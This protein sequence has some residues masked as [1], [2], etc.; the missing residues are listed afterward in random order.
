MTHF[1]WTTII[2]AV[3][4][5]AAVIFGHGETRT[6]QI[7]AIVILYIVAFG[8]GM[9]FISLQ[10]FVP[11]IYRGGTGRKQIALTFDDGPDPFSTP[12]LLDLLKRENVTATFFCIGRNVVAYPEIAKRI[13]DEGHLIGNHSHRHAWTLM[14][15]RNRGLLREFGRA[16]DAITRI[17]G[18][19]P[20]LL[21]PPVGM[22]NPHFPW[23]IKQLGVTVLAW[24]VRPLDTARPAKKVIRHV[25][26][27]A[28]DGSIVVL[29]DGGAPA[30]KITEIVGT[31]VKELRAKGYAFERVDRMI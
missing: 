5:L 8:L 12:A 13:V 23:L 31:L 11:A 20:T 30:E 26:K 9:T 25:L 14:F 29:H 21:R 24:D 17:T 1:H 27:R 3:A 15:N 19:T 10:Y 22:T 7:E 2:A 28:T 4:V 18:T 16:Q 6:T